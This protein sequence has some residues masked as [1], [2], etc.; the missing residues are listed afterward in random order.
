[1]KVEH[2]DPR[3]VYYEDVSDDPRVA[4]FESGNGWWWP[5]DNNDRRFMIVGGNRIGRSYW[6]E[7]LREM[8]TDPLPPYVRYRDPQTHLTPVAAAVKIALDGSVN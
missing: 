5:N 8:I 1:M 4:Q 7:Q 3:T 6:R 2:I